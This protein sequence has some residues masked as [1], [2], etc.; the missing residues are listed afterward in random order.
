VL[1]AG[2]HGN[3]TA[4]VEILTHCCPGYLAASWH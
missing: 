2:I 4:P 3:E 1:S